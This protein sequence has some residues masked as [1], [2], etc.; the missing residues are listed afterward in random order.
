MKCP[1]CERELGEIKGSEELVRCIFCGAK[2]DD[3]EGKEAEDIIE[4]ELELEG[5]GDASEPSSGENNSLQVQVGQ[6]EA[7]TMTSTQTS[8]YGDGAEGDRYRWLP[9]WFACAGIVAGILATVG[10]I[11]SDGKPEIRALGLALGSVSLLMVMA[12]RLAGKLTRGKVCRRMLEA[13]ALTVCAVFLG[14][15]LRI[16]LSGGTDVAAMSESSTMAMSAG[17]VAGLVGL[18]VISSGRGIKWSRIILGWSVPVWVL[19]IL[20][21]PDGQYLVN[22]VIGYVGKA[23]KGDIFLLAAVLIPAIGLS[24]YLSTEGAD[25]GGEE[26]D[27]LMPIVWTLLLIGVICWMVKGWW[28]TTG[29]FLTSSG[30]FFCASCFIAAGFAPGLILGNAELFREGRLLPEGAVIRSGWWG[31]LGGAG[32]FMS[33]ALTHESGQA[34]MVRWGLVAGAVSLTGFAWLWGRSRSA[35]RPQDG[36]WMD[37]WVLLPM[38]CLLAYLLDSL[39]MIRSV[40]VAESRLLAVLALLLWAVL[41][42][43]VLLI[44]WESARSLMNRTSPLEDEVNLLARPG[45]VA[46]A[47]GLFLLAFFG[48]PGAGAPDTLGN[49]I[50]IIR[51]LSVMTEVRGVYTEFGPHLI[52]QGLEIAGIPGTIWLSLLCV[53]GYIVHAR[54]VQKAGWLRRLM[55][56]L[57]IPVLLIGVYVAAI[58][59]MTI[60]RDCGGYRLQ[61]VVGRWLAKNRSARMILFAILVVCLVRIT[62]A[63]RRVMREEED[64]RTGGRGSVG[65]SSFR[66]LRAFGIIVCVTT[67]AV[68]LLI[69]W[70]H[71]VGAAL[72]YLHELIVES[73]LFTKGSDRVFVSLAGVP[74]FTGGV[75]GLVLSLLLAIC[76]HEET[77]RGRGESEV[78]VLFVWTLTVLL[79]GWLCWRLMMGLNWP[80]EPGVIPVLLGLTTVCMILAGY[81]AQSW[82]GLVRTF[83]EDEPWRRNITQWST[84]PETTLGRMGLFFTVMIIS[85]LLIVL[86]DGATGLRAGNGLRALRGNVAYNIERLRVSVEGISFGR[87]VIRIMT[88]GVFLMIAV[89]YAGRWKIPVVRAAVVSFWTLLVPVLMFLLGR[90]SIGVSQAGVFGRFYLGLIGVITLSVVVWIAGSWVWLVRGDQ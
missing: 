59:G 90:W 9:L 71:T 86:I 50:H 4:G 18:I 81:V 84:S 56:L 11:L 76:S 70:E 62:R 7:P 10:V 2:L 42:V 3:R 37:R 1:E 57:W 63:V 28:L 79:G 61:T 65:F 58:V 73:G 5:T 14:L 64:D 45:M 22:E 15:I 89:H 49:A 60:F 29:L 78:P 85:L 31:T 32:L 43:W 21:G 55:V 46:A 67:G 19:I 30:L 77:R 52:P 36:G 51:D 74:G 34:G 40:V 72:F 8:L 44:V 48:L 68:V 53:G 41:L 69:G 6:S 38:M 16:F 88:A 83:A 27:W 75:V 25:G 24:H 17:W 39:P 26:T 80:F 12:G 66:A 20:A 54:A 82:L 35:D 33:W 87:G 23:S 47:G 13:G